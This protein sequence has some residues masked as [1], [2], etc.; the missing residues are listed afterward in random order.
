[1][2]I[3]NFRAK[4]FP[5]WDFAFSGDLRAVAPSDGP[6]AVG[7]A[8]RRS[9]GIPGPLCGTLSWHGYGLNMVVFKLMYAT[10]V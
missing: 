3:G 6:Q 4:L 7:G 1:M 5:K 10:K 9:W 2:G 8:L